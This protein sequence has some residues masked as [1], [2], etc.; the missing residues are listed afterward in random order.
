MIIPKSTLKR[1]SGLKEQGDIKSISEASGFARQTVA[2][3]LSSGKCHDEL[4]PHI[5]GFYEEKHK[6]VES[7]Q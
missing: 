1:W 6:K 5:R 7:I 2:R 3:A 4:F